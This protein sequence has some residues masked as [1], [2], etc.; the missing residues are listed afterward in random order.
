[1]LLGYGCR[2]GCLTD[3]CDVNPDS[4]RGYEHITENWLSGGGAAGSD[5]LF[6]W[7]ACSCLTVCLPCT[8]A[9]RLWECLRWVAGARSPAGFYLPCFH[10]GDYGI[11]LEGRN[12]LDPWHI[13]CGWGALATALALM[14]E[15]ETGPAKNSSR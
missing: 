15:A 12:S 1:L 4:S 13:K 3:E 2:A 14:L 9:L 8:L 6:L 5:V 11:F 7:C 10:M